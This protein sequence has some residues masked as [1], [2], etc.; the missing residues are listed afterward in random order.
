[1]IESTNGWGNEAGIESTPMS[2]TA[3]QL[4]ALGIGISWRDRMNQRHGF[5]PQLH[6]S[7]KKGCV[8]PPFIILDP[9][10]VANAHSNPLSD[11]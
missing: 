1:M 4:N 2:A 5:S 6:Q 10:V 8:H 7:P 9:S 11:E 3:A